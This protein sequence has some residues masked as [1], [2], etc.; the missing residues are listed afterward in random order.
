M[1]QDKR[2]T[3]KIASLSGG[4]L[5]LS[6]WITPSVIAVALP[7]HAQTSDSCSNGLAFTLS[8]E[9]NSV[10]C[11]DPSFCEGLTDQ[12]I[13]DSSSKPGPSETFCISQEEQMAGEF[14]R[15][16][17][18]DGNGPTAD[19]LNVIYIIESIDSSQASGSVMSSNVDT[20]ITLN[21]TWTA[22]P[23]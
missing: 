7:S 17:D 21:G 6:R 8:I 10:V 4:S 23:A 12:E 22:V 19:F 3:I 16:I 20:L 1:N 18:L 11:N 13:I 5:L 2:S 9:F 14:M 15:N